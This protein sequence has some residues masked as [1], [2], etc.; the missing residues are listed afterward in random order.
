VFDG[1]KFSDSGLYYAPTDGNLE[2]Y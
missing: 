2:T 1:F